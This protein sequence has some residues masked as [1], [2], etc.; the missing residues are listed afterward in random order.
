MR[1]FRITVLTGTPQ[2]RQGRLMQK[3]LE[4]QFASEL[5]SQLGLPAI[6]DTRVLEDWL[7]VSH[8]GQAPTIQQMWQFVDQLEGKNEFRSW[9]ELHS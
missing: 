4:S 8:N 5:I 7:Y 1:K 6:T 3:A 9:D 2:S